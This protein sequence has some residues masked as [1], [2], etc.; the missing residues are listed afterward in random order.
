MIGLL[1]IEYIFS[2]FFFFKN[3]Y[4]LIYI[5]HYLLFYVFSSIFLNMY[6]HFCL[7]LYM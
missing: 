7:F 5:L 6:V 3:E 4:I 1:Y 2:V